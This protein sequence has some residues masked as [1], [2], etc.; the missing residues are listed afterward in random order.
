[1]KLPVRPSF[2]EAG[3][4][5]DTGSM[6]A[7]GLI[8]RLN[9]R[10]STSLRGLCPP[11]LGQIYASQESRP[12]LLAKAESVA[13]AAGIS[14]TCREEAVWFP[15]GPGGYYNRV[16]AAPGTGYDFS[17]DLI[18]SGRYTDILRAEV[19][20]AQA[21]GVTAPV[22]FASS[23]GYQTPSGY[24][25]PVYT[26]APP[27]AP[28]PPAGDWNFSPSSVPNTVQEVASAVTNKPNQS[29][30][31]QQPGEIQTPRQQTV[32]DSIGGG[33]K[34]QDQKEQAAFSSMFQNPGVLALVA[35]AGLAVLVLTR[36]GGG[37]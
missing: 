8:P 14:L 11:S 20:A 10:C 30:P 18:A 13:A 23:T 1:M 12:D 26:Y 31:F 4:V 7:L 21:A 19:A 25:A 24:T 17:A 28:A 36:G 15:D 34:D 33:L 22:Q 29:V 27:P 16:C 9:A 5:L 37:K 32:G 6:A 3:A 35:V 2:H